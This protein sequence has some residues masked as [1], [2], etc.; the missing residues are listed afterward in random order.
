M[1][2]TS[3]CVEKKSLLQCEQ[4]LLD[5]LHIDEGFCFPMAERFCG[6][7]EEIRIKT[8]GRRSLMAVTSNGILIYVMILI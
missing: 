2:R 5:G 6:G 7:T 4:R 8:D 3:F 1:E